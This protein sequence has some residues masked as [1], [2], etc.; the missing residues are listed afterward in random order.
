M[1]KTALVILTDNFEEIEA[2][3]PIDILRRAE[4]E[5]TIASRTEIRE[6]SGRTGITVIADCLLD[7][8]LG[9]GKVYDLVI[10]PG[11]P[12]HAALRKDERV[13]ALVKAQVEAGRIVGAICAAPTVLK[14]AGVLKGRKITGHFSIVEEI[15]SILQKEDVV[16]DGTIITSRGAGTAIPFALALV[17]KL[18]GYEKALK[19]AHA[20]CCGMKSIP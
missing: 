7:E 9:K 15:P 4:V 19:I 20:I 16:K 17:E 5:V 14:D 1:S 2:V 3:T 8:A 13:L 10:L 11:G 6:V 12:G 18:C